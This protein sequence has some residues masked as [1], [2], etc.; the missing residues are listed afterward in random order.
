MPNASLVL[1]Q[2]RLLLAQSLRSVCDE[3]HRLS[4]AAGTNFLAC[5]VH[6]QH[7]EVTASS[8]TLAKEA[9]G[10]PT[11]WA[12]YLGSPGLST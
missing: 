1:I 11:A 12:F 2:F 7:N 10:K 5:A 4:F 8:T 6:R 3:G 9:P